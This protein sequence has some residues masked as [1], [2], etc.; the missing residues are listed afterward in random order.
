MKKTWFI[1]FDGTLVFQKSHLKDEDYILP[2]TLDF[3]EKIVEKEDVVIITTGRGSD[4]K[5][6]ISNFLQK[7]RIKYDLII[8]DLPTG[9]RVVVNDKKTDGTLTAYSYNLTR[10]EGIKIEEFLW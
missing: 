10:D 1:D 6:R 5:D 9:P 7:H 8:C 3:F 4:H 2:G